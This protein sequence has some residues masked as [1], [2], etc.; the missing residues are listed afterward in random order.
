MATQPI[1]TDRRILDLDAEK[2]TAFHE[3]LDAPARP[4][5]RLQALLEESGFF[6]ASA[7]ESPQS[8]RSARALEIS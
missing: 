3:A 8:A 4:L 1:L 6:D 7:R 2:W 5:P